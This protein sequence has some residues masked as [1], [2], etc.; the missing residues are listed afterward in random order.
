MP[1]TVNG[2]VLKPKSFKRKALD[3]GV[4]WAWTGIFIC[5]LMLIGVGVLLETIK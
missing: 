1:Y 4:I 3:T 2:N 5:F